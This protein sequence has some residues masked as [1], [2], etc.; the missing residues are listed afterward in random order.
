MVK[1]PAGFYTIGSTLKDGFS[2]DAEGPQIS[3]YLEEF[4]IAATTVT[5]QEFQE[6]VAETGYQTEAERLG[7]SFVF[8]YFL[9]EEEKSQS[10]L[11]PNMQW[12]HAVEGACWKSPEGFDSH[13][14][15]RLD[16]PV[17]HIS[18]ND[19]VAYCQWAGKRLPTEAEWEVA[20]KGGTSFVRFPWGDAEDI[21][22]ADKANTWQGNF[23]LQNDLLDGYAGTAPVKAYSPNAYGCHQMIGNVWEWC[24]NPS[25]LDLAEFA[26]ENPKSLWEKHQ[27]ANDNFYAIRGGSFLCHPSYCRRYRIAARNRATASSSANNMGFRCINLRQENSQ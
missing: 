4:D 25:D 16:H 2:S 9:S 27:E 20:A 22:S 10:P 19:A 14:L 26:K 15:N 6:F 13:I 1:I 11:V 8:H 12:W 5:N 24:A 17:V 21:P 23:P 18:R 3:L 7:W